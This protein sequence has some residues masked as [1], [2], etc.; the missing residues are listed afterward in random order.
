MVHAGL[1]QPVHGVLMSS[2]KFLQ[3]GHTQVECHRAA[4]HDVLS[5]QMAGGSLFWGM[6]TA[7]EA[8]TTAVALW[9]LGSLRLSGRGIRRLCS[10]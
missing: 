6:L 9:G 3:Q 10:T 4:L 1:L 5:R 8:W 7:I 2:G